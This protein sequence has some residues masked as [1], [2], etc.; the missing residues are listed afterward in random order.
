MRQLAYDIVYGVMEEGGY[1]DRLFHQIIDDRPSL[2]ARD[3]GF[4][5]RLSYGT[6]ERCTELDGILDRY[7][8][9]PVHKMTKAVRT[10]LRMALY[11]IRYMDQIPEGVSCHEAVELLRYKEGQR[12]TGYVNAILREYLRH[13]DDDISYMPWEE[14]SLPKPLY[15]HLVEQYGKK[16]TRRIGEAFLQREGCITL[17]IDTSKISLEEYKELLSSRHIHS[18]KAIYMPDAISVDHVEEII[19]LPGYD[20]GY[21]YVQDESSMLPVMC[22]GIGPDDQV[23]DVCSAPGG[24]TIHALMQMRHKGFVSA[25]DISPSKVKKIQDNAKRM[26]YDN[27]ECKVWDAIDV[28]PD[29]IERADVI[30]ADVPC[31]GLGIIGR[32]PEIRYHGLDVAPEL[33]QLQRKIVK[34]AIQML[35]PGGTLMYSTC[36]INHAENEDNVDWMIGEYGMIPV[37][38]DEYLPSILKNKMTAGGMLQMIPGV[39]KSDGFFVAKLGK[40]S[41]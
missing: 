19:S 34:A 6:I 33:A 23:L 31:S 12:H 20:E 14:L 28:D 21:F 10:V 29:W 2:S 24:K 5:K 3:R 27:I 37:S 22:S 15:K 7:A 9:M 30:L 17:H 38:L 16:T 13:K 4:I 41:V 26:G 8:S 1:S 32:K 25:R 11:E 36:T 39:Q 40:P 18:D 35:K